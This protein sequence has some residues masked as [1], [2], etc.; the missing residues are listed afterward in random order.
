MKIR[1][2]ILLFLILSSLFIIQPKNTYAQFQGPDTLVNRNYLN[3]EADV[4]D[5]VDTNTQATLISLVT[6][7]S[8]FLTG[9]NPTSTNAKCLGINPKTKKVG[10]VENQ[11]GVIAIAGNLIGS[12]FEIPISSTQYAKNLADNFGITKKAYAQET[13]GAGF[14]GLLPL[15]PLWETFRNITYLIFVILFVI[16]GLGIMFRVKIDP[17]TVMTVQNQIPK[18]ILAI[19]FV[20]FSYAIAGFLIDMMYLS[21]YVIF[22]IFAPHLTGISDL[23]PVKLQGA[24]PITAVGFMGG[25]SIV[26]NV[27]FGVGNVIGGLFDG[28]IGNIIA[29]FI[30]GLIGGVATG[31]NPIGAVVGAV[32]GALLGSKLFSIIGGM[33]VF[34]VVAIAILS[35]LFRLWIML[36]KSYVYILIAVVFAPFYIAMGLIPGRAGVGGWIRNLLSNLVVFPVVLT[37]LLLGKIFSSG[38]DHVSNAFAP[39]LIGNIGPDGI[40]AIIGMGIILMLPEVANMAKDALKSPDSKFSTSIGKSISIGSSLAGAGP[41]Y[42]WQT[43]MKPANHNTG[44]DGGKGYQYIQGLPDN[45]FGR[46]IKQTL[47]VGKK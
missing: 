30:G 13:G 19:I 18:I 22:N 9:Q 41:K 4:P 33:I 6:S 40:S 37:M 36:I 42:G 35:A 7:L 38:F 1:L 14:Q 5:N 17:R 29:T 3:T 21:M 25:F 26:K 2:L 28:T 46:M 31:F 23:N 8:C 34:L 47:G 27:S 16:I 44:F 12:T 11:G 45:A 15:L 20:T 24:N 10:Y 39:P 43:L 32:G